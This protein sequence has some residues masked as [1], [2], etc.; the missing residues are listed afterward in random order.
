MRISDWSSDVC[1][2]DLVGH[3]LQGG[4]HVG[5]RERA[6]DVRSRPARGQQLG[7]LGLVALE[8]FRFVRL[9]ADELEP[10]DLDA[11]EHHAVQRAPRD[12]AGRVGDGDDAPGPA[13]RAKRWL[14]EIDAYPI[15]P[16]VGTVRKRGAEGRSQRTEEHTYALQRHMRT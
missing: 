11:L 9:E 7:E 6:A 15:D 14:G 3:E 4:A 13:H 2:S 1:S 5:E 10:A 16:D 8:L 12:L